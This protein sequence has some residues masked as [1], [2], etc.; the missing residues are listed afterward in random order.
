MPSHLRS[1]ARHPVGLVNDDKIPT[2]PHQVLESLAIEL[3]QLLSAP[4]PSSVHWLDRVQGY[5]HLWMQLPD[6]LVVIKAS[7]PPNGAEVAGMDEPEVL[8]EV[9]AELTNPL[10]CEPSRG[11]DERSLEKPSR[12]EFLE[13][14]SSFDRLAESYLISQEKADS[15]PGDRP[16]KRLYLMR[17]RCDQ[18][19]EWCNELGPRQ[20]VYNSGG[21]SS[22]GDVAVPDTG[23]GARRLR[24]SGGIHPLQIVAARN[25]HLHEISTPKL[26]PIYDPTCFSLAVEERPVSGLPWTDLRRGQSLI[27]VS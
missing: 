1:R 20:C 7:N 5:N 11:Y 4:T 27:L 18:P 21:S 13:Y 23:P 17:E 2:G 15:I 8:L 26:L 24:E 14:Q 9:C 25:P 22:P 6:V 16:R 10:I 3:R 19:L 12:L